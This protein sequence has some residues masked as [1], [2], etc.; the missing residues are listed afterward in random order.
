MN[1]ASTKLLLS[2]LVAAGAITLG[3]QAR[4][5]GEV[6]RFPENFVKGVLYATVEQGNLKEEIFTSRAAI[7]A[8]KAGQPTRAGP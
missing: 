7:D 8:V 2:G 3:W 1:A 4:A 5:G 6:V